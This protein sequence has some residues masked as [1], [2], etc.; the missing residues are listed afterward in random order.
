M[1]ASPPPTVDRPSG[2]PFIGPAALFLG[3]SQMA[4]SGFGGVMPFAY[5]FLVEE[6]RWVSPEDF[7]QMFAFGQILPGP[8]IC[9]VSVMV[10]WRKAGFV[11]AL[12]ALGGILVGPIIVVILLGVG[13]QAYGTAPLVRS[14]L[15]GMSA[16]AAG[17]I[18]ATAVKMA[19]A[20][21]GSRRQKTSELVWLV[22]FAALAFVGVGLLRWPLAGVVA[23][24]APCAVAL[25]YFKAR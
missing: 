4:L 22:V 10:G 2:P 17:L 3:F 15:T 14:A 21:F 23:I 11:G 13:Y 8:T 6:R 9:N 16:V 25:A 18:L 5:R 24:L 7:A 12:C 20:L 19:I 1:S